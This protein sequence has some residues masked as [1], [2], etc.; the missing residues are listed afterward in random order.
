MRVYG[1]A[2][3]PVSVDTS[4]FRLALEHGRASCAN[5][6]WVDAFKSLTRA[7]EAR[8]LEPDDLELLATAAYMLGRDDD[9]KRGLERAHYGHL[10]AGDVQRAARCTWW[11]GL[12]LLLRD[13]CGT[14]D[15]VVR[16][17]RA[18]PRSRAP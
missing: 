6:T 10:D 17:G 13:E 16:T 9:Y 8:P 1:R 12:C 15:G 11:I 4:S 18:A 2:G 3:E 5:G 7:D 14:G